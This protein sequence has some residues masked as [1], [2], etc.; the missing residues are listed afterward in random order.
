MPGHLRFKL[1]RLL[2]VRG[3]GQEEFQCSV[4]AHGC[5]QHEQSQNITE[6]QRKAENSSFYGS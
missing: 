3:E 5:Q 6:D 1:S 2:H 4:S